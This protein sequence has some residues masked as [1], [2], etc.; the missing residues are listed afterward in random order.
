MGTTGSARP[1]STSAHLLGMEALVLDIIQSLHYA[2]DA[3]HALFAELNRLLHR[4]LP[5]TPQQA[6]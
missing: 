1:S 2:R 3:L 5:P 4:L 6:R